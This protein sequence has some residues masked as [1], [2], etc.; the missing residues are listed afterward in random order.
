MSRATKTGPSCHARI[1]ATPEPANAT[2]T[3]P[4]E[5]ERSRTMR[6]TAAAQASEAAISSPLG[7]TTDMTNRTIGVSADNGPI[8]DHGLPFQRSASARATNSR[9]VTAETMREAHR[10]VDAVLDAVRASA[11]SAYERGA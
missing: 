4:G 6:S 2:Q 9:Q 11:G 1:A 3:Q 5:P 7:L 8:S 10:P